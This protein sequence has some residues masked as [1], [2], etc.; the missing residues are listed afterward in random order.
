MRAIL[1]GALLFG[2][3]ASAPAAT[4]KPT[5]LVVDTS[6]LTVRGASFGAREAVVVTVKREGRLLARRS[7]RT[8]AA[9]RFAVTFNDTAIGV[10]HRCNGGDDTTIVARSASGAVAKASLPQTLCPPP[11]RTPS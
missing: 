4:S 7:V 1:I 3:A 6:P 8:G 11:L 2:L 5:L 9:G 10:G